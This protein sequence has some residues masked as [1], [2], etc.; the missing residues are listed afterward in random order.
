MCNN[1]Y[2]FDSKNKNTWP[3]EN[4]FILLWTESSNAPIVCTFNNMNFIDTNGNY[5]STLGLNKYIYS[6]I[7]KKPN[8]VREYNV[9]KCSN[10]EKAYHCEFC[11]DG[12]CMKN[13]CKYQIFDKEYCIE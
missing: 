13:K 10:G 9:T 4:K 11:D 5:Y 2:V 6:Y 8:I 7:G 3:D 1:Y 12:Y